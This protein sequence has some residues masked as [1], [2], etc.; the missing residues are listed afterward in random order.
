MG[1]R[2]AAEIIKEGVE[3]AGVTYNAADARPLT[4]LKLW[5][6]SVALGWQWPEVTGIA[7]ITLA[8]GEW[9]MELGLGSI[10]VTSRPI[11]RLL[12]PLKIDYGPDIMQRDI[13][14]E[15]YMNLRPSPPEGVP[16]KAGYTRISNGTIQIAFNRRPLVPTNIQITYN[17][18]PQ[19]DDGLN[20][21]PWYPNDETTIEA[22]AFKTAEYHDGKDA[23]TTKAFA[24]HLSSMLRNDKIK[25]G[26]VENFTVKLERRF[27]GR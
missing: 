21:I 26:N 4:W 22:I 8:A 12:F 14:Q 6:D 27:G 10:N 9:N 5:L 25:F 24:E 11:F 19:F 20:S 18:L 7:F 16:T 15:P 23:T 1:L 13:D 17:Y 3:K 2:T